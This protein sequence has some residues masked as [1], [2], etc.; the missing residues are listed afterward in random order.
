MVVGDVEAGGDGIPDGPPS[1]PLPTTP[2]P[3][4]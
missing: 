2:T 1:G 3:A 4:P